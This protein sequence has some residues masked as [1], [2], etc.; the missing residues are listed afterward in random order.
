MLLPACTGSG[1]AALVTVSSPLA[2]VPTTVLADAVLF[3]EFG[4]VTDELTDTE[5]LITVPFVVPVLTF[6]TIVNVPAVRPAML[7]SVQTT[8]PVPPA[9]EELQLHPVGAT[10]DT[11]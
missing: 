3:E 6:T 11:K 4:S 7:T 1:E 2:V 9:P 8:L 10:M 5:L